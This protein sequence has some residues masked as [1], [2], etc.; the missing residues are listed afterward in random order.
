MINNLKKQIKNVHEKSNEAKSKHDIDVLE[1]I[2]IELKHGVAKL[3][4]ENEKLHKENVHLK[5]TYKNL[6]DSIK[7]TGVQTKDHNESLIAQINR[8][9]FSP[10][11]SFA[12]NEKPSTP[13]SCL[14][15]KP[16]G[17]IFKTSGLRWIPTGKIFTNCTTK[18]DSEPP[19]GSNEDVT[20]PYTCNQTL[21]VGAVPEVPAALTSSHSL[22]TVDQDAPSTST[23]QT[24]SEQQSSLL[25]QGVED[26][27]YNIEV[28]HM[29]KDP[30]FGISILEPSF[31]ET[32]LQG[33]IPSNINHLNQSFD[34]LTKLKKKH[35]LKNVIGDPSR[36][37]KENSKKDKIGSTPDKN[38][39]RGE[40]VFFL[41][42]KDEASEV[43]IS[44]IKKTQVNLQLQVQRVRTDNGTE[45]K[46]KTLAKFFDEDEYFD[47]SKIMKSST[48]NVETS[49]NEEV[50]HEVSES[51]QGESSL[52]SLNDAEAL[53]D[54]D[55]VSAM[56]EELDQFARLNF[57]YSIQL[58]V[59]YSQQEGIDYDETFA[60]VARI[61]AIRLFLAYAT[62]KDFTIFQMDVKTSFLNGILKKE[63][64]VGQ[65]PGFAS[66]QY[67]N[68][69]YALDKALYGLKQAPRTI[70]IDLPQSLPSQL[71]KLGLG[72]GV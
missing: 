39:K 44:F 1:I 15:W 6:Y 69:V 21:K 70:E 8:Y 3:L 66:K 29:D 51:F 54:A 36:P 72:D 52:F 32:T 38:E 46:N 30:Y 48:T 9:R 49:I 23:S 64:Y 45:F 10:N 71:G 60:L 18:V 43:I 59:G 56:Q 58:A 24:T 28:A 37:V 14:R 67:P 40:A 61:E 13:R 35:P 50:F 2:K 34:T 53:K 57:R 16:T 19:N 62:H 63:V 47:S 5:Q 20:N 11:K 31:K 68:H 22:T 65:P 25:P 33:V 27:F 41:H 7:K 12:V 4:A 17:R 42:S 26:G 55:W